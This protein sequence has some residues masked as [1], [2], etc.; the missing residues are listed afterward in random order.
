M[1][2]EK[3]RDAEEDDAAFKLFCC[4][5]PGAA[6][7]LTRGTFRR[8]RWARAKR[9]PSSTA[10]LGCGF[11]GAVAG[12]RA[13]EIERL[14]AG[15]WA[16]PGGCK[17]LPCV[18]RRSRAV[19]SGT[20]LHYLG[21]GVGLQRSIWSSA[22]GKGASPNRYRLS[23]EDLQI[24]A[25]LSRD[26]SIDNC[27][28]ASA[29]GGMPAGTR[30]PQLILFKRGGCYNRKGNNRDPDVT[31]TTNLSQNR[32]SGTNSQSLAAAHRAV[33]SRTIRVRRVSLDTQ[34]LR[35]HR[36]C[37]V[38]CAETAGSLGGADRNMR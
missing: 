15:T 22:R 31:M 13:P 10:A 6:S 5:D 1:E 38:L 4:I 26:A 19:H 3:G 17:G 11:R 7:S 9:V 27:G 16:V 14:V 29:R 34:W 23:K 18:A 28:Q 37:L 24:A 2:C 35:R 30:F 12:K 8:R 25:P 20:Y 21:S 36:D 32:P 33:N